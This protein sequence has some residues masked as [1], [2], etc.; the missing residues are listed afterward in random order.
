[1]THQRFAPK[2]IT[3]RYPATCRECSADLPAGA[4]AIWRGYAHAHHR[5]ACVACDPLVEARALRRRASS[6]GPW[7]RLIDDE[8]L[9]NHPRHLASERLVRQ[10]E[11]IEAR[12]EAAREAAWVASAAAVS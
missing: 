8:E 11:E 1:M 7:G 3:L 5:V 12:V 2:T 10:A 4:T 6:L 9:A